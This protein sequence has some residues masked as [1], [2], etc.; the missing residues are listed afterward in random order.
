MKNKTNKNRNSGP[1]N[2]QTNTKIVWNT[3]SC[4]AS[5]S[6]MAHNDATSTSSSVLNHFY[7][8]RFF[9]IEASWSALWSFHTRRT[10]LNTL[11]NSS[12]EATDFQWIHSLF[13][14]K[15]LRETRVDRYTHWDDLTFNLQLNVIYD[16]YT[17]CYSNVCFISVAANVRVFGLTKENKMPRC[18][19]KKFPLNTQPEQCKQRVQKS[20]KNHI[21]IKIYFEN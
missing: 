14:Y 12:F 2:R 6:H 16:L 20:K 3:F 21:F 9:T 13:V 19:V 1:D 5:F 11:L 17:C 18:T 4:I 10:D 15:F 8:I 7:S